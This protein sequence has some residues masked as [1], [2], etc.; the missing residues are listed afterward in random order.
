MKKSD[1]K[2][3]LTWMRELQ[4]ISQIG[5]TYCED[6][7][8][9]ER[10]ERLNELAAEIADQ[11]TEIDHV[12]LRNLFSKEV[13]YATPK[14][15]V[16]AAVF[17]DNKLLMVQESEDGLWSLPGGWAEINLS[18]SESA[19]KEVYEESGFKVVVRK[20]LALYDKHKHDHPPQ[21]PHTYKAIFLAEIVGGE[22][23]LSHETLAVD[24]FSKEN[25]PPLSTNRITERQIQRIFLHHS[26]PSMETDFD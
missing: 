19:A 14:I 10:Y 1:S 5:R 13:G 20:L 11:F 26:S 17:H 21:W 25:L 15:D 8:C 7:F 16:R 24:F 4:G 22:A 18:P 12:I 3:W 9:Q 2:L 6:K 23:R